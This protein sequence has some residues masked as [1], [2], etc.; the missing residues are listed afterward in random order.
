[1]RAA[2]PAE[3]VSAPRT[4]Y[5]ISLGDLAQA[6][7]YS[8]EGFALTDPDGNYVYI[9]NAHLRIYGYE[10][11]QDLL[12]RSWRTLYRPEW[13]RY[14]EETVIP[15]LPR[16]QFWRG[17]VLGKKRDGA[18]FL[19][20]V[21]LTLLPD[22]K[23]TCNC[24]DESARRDS[25]TGLAGHNASG[26]GETPAELR[27]LG[28]SLVMALPAKLRRP[29]DM[30][31]GYCSFLLSE[32]EAGREPAAD[33]LRAGLT[34]IDATGRNLAEQMRRLDVI[35]QLLARGFTES[36]RCDCRGDWIRELAP[37]CHRKAAA[38]GRSQDLRVVLDDA[39]LAMS[40]P[41]LECVVLELLANALQFSR[42]GDSVQI[43]GRK[44]GAVYELRVCDEGAGLPEGAG[45][46]RNERP[47]GQTS[48][49]G[50]GLAVVKF[51]LRRNG[52][53]FEVERSQTSMTC[54]KA[55]LPLRS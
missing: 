4:H 53:T 28:E 35:A 1:M 11:P 10:R 19:A 49:S 48:P 39:A 3:R 41:E 15:V 36:D 37:T 42:A 40:Y 16:D 47:F 7:D 54:L 30:L 33:S 51:I 32:L 17:Q 12:G 20:E 46:N 55:T 23:I 45:D 38:A 27:E 43:C 5:P 2:F 24:R 18:P 44:T 9:N 29:L 50:F 14:F 26:A 21:T 6:L 34:K 13:V 22:G 52:A 8:E 31:T 25:P